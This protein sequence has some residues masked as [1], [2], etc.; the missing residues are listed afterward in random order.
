MSARMPRHCAGAVVLGLLA[1]LGDP[2][3]LTG[4]ESNSAHQTPRSVVRTLQDPGTLIRVSAGESIPLQVREPIRTGDAIH[5]TAGA[6]AE[7]TVADRNLLRLDRGT[8]IAFLS[9]LDS[10]RTTE[11]LAALEL[12]RGTVHLLLADQLAGHLR[13]TIETGNAFAELDGPGSY[14][15]RTDAAAKTVLIVRSGRAGLWT[16][17]GGIVVQPG[18]EVQVEGLTGEH[19]RR[20]RAREPLAL[21]LWGQL[22]TP[23]AKL[24]GGVSPYPSASYEPIA[25]QHFWIRDLVKFV[26]AVV[27]LAQGEP[28]GREND[29]RGVRPLEVALAEPDGQSPSS[30]DPVSEPETRSPSVDPKQTAEEPDQTDR[31]P[32]PR[33]KPWEVEPL[34]DPREK[35]SVVEPSV[36]SREPKPRQL[37][38]KTE[39]REDPSKPE[40][41][42][43]PSKPESR[44]KP[45]KSESRSKP[46]KS[47][48]RSKPSKSESRS[49]PSKSESRSKPSAI[50]TVEV[51][52]AIQTV[53]VRVAEIEVAGQASKLR[54][55]ITRTVDKAVVQIPETKNSRSSMSGPPAKP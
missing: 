39:L 3:I 25:G 12:R 5:T 41:R 43:K 47:E 9:S 2:A 29:A 7:L 40:S 6:R 52:V 28:D 15:L 8:E 34:D 30:S 51:R 35:P 45:S 33:P 13:P 26:V 50:Q 23:D 14:I 17:G 55:R 18:D 11:R 54:R 24:A 49:K 22:L 27:D 53:E 48:S 10:P 21:E 46:S 37:P 20:T 42:S 38:P 19:V 4:Q 16:T 44:S 1:A 31:A 32:L 36:D